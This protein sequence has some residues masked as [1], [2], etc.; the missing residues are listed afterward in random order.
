MNICIFGAAY[1]EIDDCYK[2]ETYL[3]GKSMAERGHALIF[4]AGGAGLMGAAARGVKAGGGRITGVVPAF[5][6]KQ[7]VRFPACDELIITETM[8]ERKARM[9]DGC[10]AF[11]ILPGGL[12]TLDEFFETLVL[13]SFGKQPKP[14]AVF[15]IY[16]YYDKLKEFLIHAEAEKFI[17]KGRLDMY[18]MFNS[19]EQLLD[20]LE[21]QTAGA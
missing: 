13:K 11:L 19:R 5:F 12:G 20:D 1:E 18:R 17:P 15:N 3:L 2:E 7:E 6:T 16:G 10:D 4:G 9:E 21:R 8:R 14:M